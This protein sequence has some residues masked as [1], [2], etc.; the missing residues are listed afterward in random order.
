[1]YGGKDN[2][3]TVIVSQLD[4]PVDFLDKLCSRVVNLVP[5]DDIQTAIQ[6]VNA[7]TQT[8][9]IY[10]ESLKK[11]IR[12]DLIMHGVQRIVLWDLHRMGHLPLLKMLSNPC[13]AC[14]SG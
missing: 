4:E 9:G 11:T 6:S 13:D 3:G 10:P 12:N 1:M 7:Y 5:I 2:E 14:V 8:V